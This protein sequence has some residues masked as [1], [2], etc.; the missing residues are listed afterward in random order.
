[1]SQIASFT[2]KLQLLERTHELEEEEKERIL[3]KTADRNAKSREIRAKNDLLCQRAATEVDLKEEAQQ[4]KALLSQLKESISGMPWM[5]PMVD[6][7]ENSQGIH[8]KISQHTFLFRFIFVSL[9]SRR[10]NFISIHL[11]DI[12][13]PTFKNSVLR[14]GIWKT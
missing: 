9:L 2:K 3:R 6:L 12:Q 7:L 11:L 1:M 13:K 10:T 14:G 4:R 8:R 5:Q